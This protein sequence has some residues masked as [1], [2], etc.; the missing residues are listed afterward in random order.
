MRGQGATAR[1]A[2]EFAIRVALVR[3]CGADAV[4]ERVRHLVTVS[5][6]GDAYRKTDYDDPAPPTHTDLRVLASPS[7]SVEYAIEALL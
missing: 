5:I 3:V 4:V 6:E 7:S 1:L 2:A